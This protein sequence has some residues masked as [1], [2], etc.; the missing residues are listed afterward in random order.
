MEYQTDD[1]DFCT[2]WLLGLQSERFIARCPRWAAEHQTSDPYFQVS[3]VLGLVPHPC[4]ASTSPVASKSPVKSQ[5]PE[6][7][8]QFESTDPNFQVSALLGLP[9]KRSQRRRNGGK[10]DK[11]AAT[12][13]DAGSGDEDENETAQSDGLEASDDY[14]IARMIGEEPYEVDEEDGGGEAEKEASGEKASDEAPVLAT[15]DFLAMCQNLEEML[16][17]IE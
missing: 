4:A 6:W 9:F 8:K 3:H 1:A 2:S 10:K 15:A 14:G 7:A 17:D 13:Q 16:T 12:E 5:P 11:A